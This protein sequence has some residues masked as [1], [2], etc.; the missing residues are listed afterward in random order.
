MRYLVFAY[1]E[2]NPHGGWGDFDS[3]YDDKVSAENRAKILVA[4]SADYAHVVNVDTL[5]V[6][7]YCYDNE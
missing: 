5:E 6:E 4:K 2:Y 1:D 7:E 3:A